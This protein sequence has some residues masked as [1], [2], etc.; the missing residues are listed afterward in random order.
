MMPAPGEAEPGFAETARGLIRGA[1][2]G[3]LATLLKGEA[4]PYASL[5]LIAIDHDASPILML[6]DLADHT[7]NLATDPRAS[8]L[9]DATRGLDNPLAGTR[10]GL[11]GTIAKSA[12]PR[13]RRRFLARHA[14]AGF[15]ADFH[16]F[17][18]YR[19]QIERLHLVAGFGRIRW[20]EA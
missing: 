1:D 7:K 18:V 14:D 2:R 6:S 4:R 19:M 13:H 9:V 3:S 5:V 12:E 16:D 15:Y 17:N 8:L 20:I 11:V 10:A